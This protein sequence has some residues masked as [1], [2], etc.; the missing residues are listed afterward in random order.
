MLPKHSRL[1]KQTIATYLIKAR[2][3]RTDRFIV[4]FTELPNVKN[5]AISI[6]VSKK[7]APKAVMRNHLRRRGYAAVAPLI[8]KLK[9]NIGI[10]VSYT[11][12]DAKTPIIELKNEL[13]SAFSKAKLYK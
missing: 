6:V 3:V 5:P 11:S 4:A 10:L 13:D 1:T 9:Q 8:V 7:V 2:R 12:K